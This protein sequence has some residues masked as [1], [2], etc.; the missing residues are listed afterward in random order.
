M[1]KRNKY[2]VKELSESSLENPFYRVDISEPMWINYTDCFGYK[3]KFTNLL[4]PR[5]SMYVYVVTKSVSPIE[6][7][8]GLKLIMRNDSYIE[9]EEYATSE[10]SQYLYST[11]MNNILIN[12]EKSICYFLRK[13]RTNI[14]H[15]N[16]FEVGNFYFYFKVEPA[17]GN[18][19]R[20]EGFSTYNICIGFI[21]KKPYSRMNNNSQAYIKLH[22]Y[23]IFDVIS[24]LHR[25]L[26]GSYYFSEFSSSDH[27]F[28]F[29]LRTHDYD[30]NE[31]K[32][33]LETE[34]EYMIEHRTSEAKR[35]VNKAIMDRYYDNFEYY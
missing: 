1:F 28:D 35:E 4:K 17:N 16:Y 3:V 23:S 8:V 22:S 33:E 24:A 9:W 20:S 26:D 32:F 7:L 18:W 30:L 21:D 10:Y 2:K 13:D 34:L 12:L 6:L 5:E 15:L 31:I 14:I 19:A 29:L 25:L 27:T 11:F